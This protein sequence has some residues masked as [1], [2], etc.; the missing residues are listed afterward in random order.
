MQTGDTNV[1]L[2]LLMKE[3]AGI[4]TWFH[5]QNTGTTT[6]TVDVVYSDGLQV[7]GTEIA[8]GSSA[9]FDQGLEAHAPGQA[10]SGIITSTLPVVATVIEEETAGNLMYAYN[11]YGKNSTELGPGLV[12]PLVNS[13]NNGYITGV[14]IQNAGSVQTTVTLT[15]T[16]EEGAGTPTC[17]ETHVLD[18]S[19]MEVF[20]LYP[21]AGYDPSIGF[22]GASSTCDDLYPNQA[23]FVGSA[24]I[25]SNSA[26]QNLVTIS[27]QL[28][29]ADGGVT[30][31]DG[32]AAGGFNPAVATNKFVLP[33]LLEHYG[34]DKYTSSVNLMRVGGSAAFTVECTF[35]DNAYIWTS[36]LLDAD[37]DAAVKIFWL[38]LDPTGGA[39]GGYV[40]S[41]ICTASEPDGK[42]VAIINQLATA[43]STPGDYLLVYEA[44]PVE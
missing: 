37:G 7:L 17:T 20:A 27:Q 10:F 14:Q 24:E 22:P 42:I 35:S 33:L 3:N 8:A 26:S 29:S 4:D 31:R 44:L 6:T 40:G 5:I 25:T 39:T 23:K 30:F 19:E 9:L 2:P 32:E 15:Y 34:T 43:P 16:P 11:G 38:N 28:G 12:I 36:P 21:F 18:P 13:N 41:G 1:L